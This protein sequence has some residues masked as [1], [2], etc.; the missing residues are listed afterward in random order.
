MEV[1]SPGS[2]RTDH[3]AKR[4]D[5]AD[6]GIP[7]YWIVDLDPRCRCSPATSPVSSRTPTAAQ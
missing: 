5:Y 2:H 3:V 6:A 7:H 1:L 4:A